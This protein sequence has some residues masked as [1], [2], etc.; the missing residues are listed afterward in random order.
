MIHTF[1]RRRRLPEPVP[2]LRTGL[3]VA[4]LVLLGGLGVGLVRAEEEEVPRYS[5]STRGNR[6]AQLARS[7]VV[8]LAAEVFG[9]D[10]A[11][12]VAA[13]AWCES[14]HRPGARNAGWDRVFGWYDYVGLLQIERGIWAPTAL[15]LTG[16]ADLTDPWVNLVTG[17]E[18]QRRQGW[19]AWP[20]CS[21]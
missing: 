1:R 5:P 18:I 3:V 2:W 20:W 9:A 13:I 11:P 7:E 17:R 10:L 21:R 15:A 6:P 4:L 12:Y 19:R 8:D 14:S 16:S